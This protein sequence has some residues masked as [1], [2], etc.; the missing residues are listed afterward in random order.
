MVTVGDFE[1]EGV[2]GEG[3]SAIVYAARRRRGVGGGASAGSGGGVTSE[4]G[5]ASDAA[6]TLDRGEELALKVLRPELLLSERESAAFL[7]EAHRAQRVRHPS[8]VE[9]QEAG[10]LPDGRPYLVM[11]RIRGECLAERVKRGPFAVES[12]LRLFRGLA[13]AIETLHAAGLVHRDIKPENVFVEGA[14]AR[15]VLLDLGI[16]RDIDAPASTTTQAGLVRGTPAYMAPERFFGT[17]ASALT[18]TYEAAVLLYVMLT[19]RLPWEQAQEARGRMS[20]RDPRTLVTMAEPLAGALLRAL[21][22]DDRARQQGIRE[23]VEELEHAAISTADTTV[24]PVLGGAT[25]PAPT[26]PSPGAVRGRGAVIALSAPP[27]AGDF[28]TQDTV[29]LSTGRAP[30]KGR[31]WGARGGGG[32]AAGG[33]GGGRGDVRDAARA[34]RGRGSRSGGGGE[35]ER[36]AGERGVCGGGRNRERGGG[37]DGG[38]RGGERN[39]RAGR[40]NRRRGGERERAGE[41]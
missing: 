37:R 23:L 38:E 36:G 3:G 15:L 8:L 1:I 17:R 30:R 29:A 10:M 22:I 33:G 19:G 20:P 16:A 26:L 13:E 32:V 25:P 28:A 6:P 34:G 40:R 7:E 31:G 5:V 27:P 24:A 4:G 11:P 14:E 21:S 18:D 2:L 39:G 41:R 9:I 12:A 35:L